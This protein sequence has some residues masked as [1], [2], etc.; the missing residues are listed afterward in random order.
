MAA[1]P[2]DA[3]IAS[4]AERRGCVYTRYV[5]DLIVSGPSVAILR[6]MR[7]VIEE[8]VAAMGWRINARKTRIQWA[9]AGRR[10]LCGVAVDADGLHPTRE[11]RRRLRAALHQARLRPQDRRQRQRA[12]GLREWAR[13]KP[14]RPEGRQT[15]TAWQRTESRRL[16]RLLDCRRDRW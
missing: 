7:A 2:M 5:D 9:G 10:I 4:E 12:E 15:L 6:E 1:A 8:A 13:C 16:E 3:V 11:T 14:P